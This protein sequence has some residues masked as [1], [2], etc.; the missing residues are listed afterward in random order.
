MPTP[1]NLQLVSQIRQLRGGPPPNTG[2][3]NHRVLL[4]AALGK[5]T[6]SLA[7]CDTCGKVLSRK[8]AATGAGAQVQ[9]ML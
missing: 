8:E 9:G 1:T 5:L 3:V 6:Q 2:N 4:W 7:R